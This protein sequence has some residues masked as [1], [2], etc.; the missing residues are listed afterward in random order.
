M[1]TRPTKSA[2]RK[3]Y[4]T[5]D[6]IPTLYFDPLKAYQRLDFYAN[7]TDAFGKRSKNKDVISAA[8]VG[9]YEVMFKQRLS[10]DDLD[11]MVVSADMHQGVIEGLKARGIDS[12]GGRPIEEVIITGTGV[13]KS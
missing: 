12:I 6:W 13:S 9:A 11:V 4:G 3:R 7:Y 10:W 1:F 2:D 5:T 8:Q